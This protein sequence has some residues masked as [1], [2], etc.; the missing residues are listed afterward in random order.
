[1]PKESIVGMLL[2][3]DVDYMVVKSS[4]VGLFQHDIFTWQCYGNSFVVE[5]L[6]ERSKKIE[7]RLNQKLEEISPSDRQK[8]VETIFSIFE[9][10]DIRLTKDIKFN[11]ILDLL[12]DVRNIDKDVKKLVFDLIKAA[13]I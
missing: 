5:S 10:N 9:E 8:I 7:K 3:H 1:V 13:F 6:S 4:T 11:K 12:K 2:Y